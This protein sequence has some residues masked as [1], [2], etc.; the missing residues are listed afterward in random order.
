MT[1]LLLERMWAEATV[2]N[3][4]VLFLEGTEGN[5]DKKFWE[6]LIDH[7]P[8]YDTGHIENDAS[9]NSSIVVRVFVTEL[10]LLPSRCL[11]TIGGFFTEPLTSNDRRIFTEPLSSNDGGTFNEPLPSNR[12]I[13]TEPLPSN[14]KGIHRHTETATWCHNPTSYFSQNKKSRLKNSSQGNGYTDQN[15]NTGPR[16]LQQKW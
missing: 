8:W 16:E 6:E 3:F 7:F 4:K 15:L 9:N 2:A 10:T 14:D 11:A 13:F 1:G 12:R 5:K